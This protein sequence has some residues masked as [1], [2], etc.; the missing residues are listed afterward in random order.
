M[1][2]SGTSLSCRCRTCV[3]VDMLHEREL[4]VQQGIEIPISSFSPSLSTYMAVRHRA[5]CQVPSPPITVLVCCRLQAWLLDGGRFAGRC[6]VAMQAPIVRWSSRCS[7][8]VQS[9]RIFEFPCRVIRQT[10]KGC[11][12]SQFL[13]MVNL[14]FLQRDGSRSSSSILSHQ[15]QRLARGMEG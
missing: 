9:A 3:P 8:C 6:V 2:S 1:S 7:L 12:P 5:V 4:Q 14:R 10:L 11:P 15:H 13:S